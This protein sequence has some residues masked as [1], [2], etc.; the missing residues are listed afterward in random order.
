VHPVRAQRR[1]VATVFAVHGAVMGSFAARIPAIAEHLHLSAGELGAALFAPAVGALL[2]MSFTARLLHATGGQRATKI[3]MAAWCL[4][5]S[6]PALAPNL[7]L[8]AVT[9][10]IYGAAGGMADV[11]MNTAGSGLEQRMGTSIMSS[12]HGMWSVGGFLAAGIAVVVTH[13]GAGPIPHLAGMS[14]LTLVIGQSAAAR[15]QPDPAAD[16][17]LAPPRLVLPSGAVLAIGLVAFCSVF[18]EVAGTDWCAVYLRRV[19]GST[20]ATAAS[21]YA[22]FAVT[23]AVLRLSGDRVVNRFGATMTVRCGAAVSTAG[24]AL[25]VAAINAPLTIAGF[26]LVG[27]GI[28]VVVPLAFAAAGR[29]G[30]RL[31]GQTGAGAAIAGVATVG[32]GAGLAAPAAIGGIASV[33]S[34][35][36]SFVVVT[37]LLALIV[38]FGGRLNPQA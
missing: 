19:I 25:I 6:L 14:L 15:L 20:D 3:L 29:V 1:A 11:A 30:R 5:L 26:G 16:A 2:A 4:A 24:S 38:A 22:V 32:Y 12:L 17:S 23:M 33:T 7:P 28:A 13:A 10:L 37:A 35:S 34:L 31:G 27:A 21:A 36:A 8:L 9:L 18:A